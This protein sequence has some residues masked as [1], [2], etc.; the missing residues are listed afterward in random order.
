MSKGAERE[1]FAVEKEKEELVGPEKVVC[2]V[3]YSTWNSKE[4]P[5]FRNLWISISEFETDSFGVGFIE[6]NLLGK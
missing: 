1:L 4:I 3:N 2:V 5:V 6:R